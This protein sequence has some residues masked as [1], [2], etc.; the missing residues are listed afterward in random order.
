MSDASGT[1]ATPYCVI[2]RS[3]RVRDDHREVAAIVEEWGIELIVVGL[4][5]SLDGSEGIGATAARAEAEAL[6]V[7]T[8]VPVEPYDERLT[9]VSAHRI[10][11]DRGVGGP[12]RR[13]VVDK[14]AAAV[15]LQAWLDGQAA[16]TAPDTTQTPEPE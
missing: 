9:T 2:E 5:L 7:V 11:R 8:G 10:L 3:K 15:L 4:P 16:R 14:V 6:G 1:L 13:K 12:G